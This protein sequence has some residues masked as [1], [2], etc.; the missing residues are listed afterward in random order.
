MNDEEKVT[1]G[2][3]RESQVETPDNEMS[4]INVS[5]KGDMDIEKEIQKVEKQVAFFLKIKI[6]S[7]KLTKEKDWVFQQNSPYLMD[8]GTENVA[9]AWGID[10][11]DVK[12]KQEWEEDNK[13]RYYTYVATGKAYS[14]KLGRYVEDIGVCS[15]RDK[16]F[17]WVKGEM[18]EVHDVDMA[19]IR[20]KAVTN[21]YSRLIKR[22]IGLMS[23]TTEDLIE[24]G[25]DIKKIQGIKY[26]SGSQ[27]AKARL[28]AKGKEVQQKLGDMLLM[29][30][31]NDE[32][33]AKELLA[34]YSAWKDDD[35]KEHY[36]DS[37]Q[38]MSEKWLMTT[39]GKAKKDFE[40]IGGSEEGEQIEM[41]DEEEN[42][43]ND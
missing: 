43:N 17:G 36:A 6:V 18:K 27:K 19:N 15:Q 10:I 39:Y 11:S 13:G 7:L 30:A 8:R 32:K 22:C 26:N 20:K 24:A 37:F 34:Q 38:K 29:M 42:E 5:A 1:N 41:N 31:N 9:I 21:L 2:E 28:S 33:K 35:G 25:L 14:K 40:K 12:L 3:M 4:I 23:V 16:F